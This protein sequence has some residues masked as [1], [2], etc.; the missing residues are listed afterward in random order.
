MICFALICDQSHR[1]DSWFGSGDTFEA[2][3]K[4]G[5]VSCPECGSASVKK[6]IMAP[7]VSKGD[8][9]APKTLSEPASPKE[10]N[11]KK[12]REQVESNAENVGLSFAA[13]ARAIHDGSAPERAIFGEA[14]PADAKALIEDGIPVMPL[15]FTPTRKTN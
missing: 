15:P 3:V 5:H 6:T 2:L 10:A 14:K 13:E 12:L 7:R 1:F 8:V 9:F 11:L 4:A